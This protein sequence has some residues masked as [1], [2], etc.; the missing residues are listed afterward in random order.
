MKASQ[1]AKQAGL[2]SLAQ[3]SELTGVSFQ[4]LNNWANSKPDLFEVVLL[5]CVDKILPVKSTKNNNE[6]FLK[7]IDEELSFIVDGYYAAS[8][9][10]LLEKIS[11]DLIE[12]RKVSKQ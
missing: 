8:V 2:K 7:E 9:T 11:S 3:V 6:I 5:G 4:T 12:I 10:P 1:Q